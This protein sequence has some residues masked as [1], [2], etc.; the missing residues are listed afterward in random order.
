M[1]H[2]AELDENNTVL[3]VIVVSN[4]DTA[5]EAGNEVEAIGVPFCE[6][7]LGGTWVQTSYN[8]N[9]RRQ[10]AGIGYTYDPEADI[11]VSPSP[12]PSWVKVV[13]EHVDW[14]PPTPRP[15]D[16]KFYMWEEILTTWLEDV[17]PG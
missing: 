5:D 11:F 15:D 12:F 7:L 13:N 4:D 10:Y 16:G 6:N 2:F 1:A 14:E 17:D 9:I 8:D 3:R